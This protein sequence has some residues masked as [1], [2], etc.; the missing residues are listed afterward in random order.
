MP[1]RQPF[2]RL[3]QL[4][5]ATSNPARADLHAHTTA[6]D[7]GYTPS[8][9]V[10][11]AQAAGLKAIAITDHDTIAGWP[12]ALA[13]IRENR[14]GIEFVRGIEISTFH[15]LRDWHLLAYDVRETDELK[16]RL[17]AIQSARRERFLQFVDLL[18]E[19]GATIPSS[20]IEPL[21]GRT[22]SLGRR[23]LA[24]ALVE[25]GIVRSRYE[26]FRRFLIPLANRVERLR[27]LSLSDAIAIIHSA[28][29]FAS[30]AHPPEGTSLEELQ[31]FRDLGLDAVEVEFP[32]ATRSRSNRLREWAG[33]LGIG[34]TG[35]SDSHG[36]DRRIGSR[37]ISMRDLDGLRRLAGSTADAGGND[38]ANSARSRG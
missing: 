23:H 2:T 9:V 38:A 26:A 15:G 34:C 4:A 12:E 5:A 13:T 33:Q 10:A 8:Q 16:E 19:Q 22:I 3:C 6:S 24:S 32:A 37:T 14:F 7:G 36:D 35:G 11:F 18:N 27:V 28:G 1:R 25:T 31:E 20:S 29:G 17:A 30:L 21:L